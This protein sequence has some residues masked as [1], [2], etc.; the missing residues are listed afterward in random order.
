MNRV[1][2]GLFLVAA[3]RN[4]DMTLGLA[5][6][7]HLS[8][9]FFSLDR[10]KYNRLWPRYLSD[11]HHLRTTYPDRWNERVGGSL[12]VSNNEIPFTYVGA[13]HACEHLNRQMKVKSGLV[14]ISKL[15]DKTVNLKETNDIYGRLMILAKST[16]NIDAIGNQEFTIKPRSLF[17]PDGSKLRCTDKSKLIRLLEMLGKEAKLE[18]GRLASEETGCVYECSMDEDAT[19]FLP[20]DS[21]DVDRGFAVVDGM[22]IL[23]KMQSTAPG[24]VVDLS[25]SFTDLLLSMTRECDEIILVFDTYTMCLL[26]MRLEKHGYRG[27]VQCSTRSMM[28]RASNILP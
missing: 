22:V 5:A 1:E 15:R 21:L 20:T 13:D 16:I 28:K 26:N 17:S 18:Q 12:S 6:G 4:A 2:V 9:L 11:M 23:H 7:E 27:S 14:G 10:I 25:H 19:H 8:K 3:S 24:I